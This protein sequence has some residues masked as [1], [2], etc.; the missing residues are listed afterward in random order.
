MLGLSSNKSGN[1]VSGTVTDYILFLD[2]HGIQCLM[3]NSN[4]VMHLVDKDDTV[5]EMVNFVDNLARV[6]AIVNGKVV[7]QCGG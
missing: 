3:T 7:M 1:L 4:L 5:A 2:V 6:G